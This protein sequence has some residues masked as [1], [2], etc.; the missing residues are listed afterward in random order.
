MVL[1][2]GRT[3]L[4]TKFLDEGTQ[5]YVYLCIVDG[6]RAC[7]KI[8]K[9]GSATTDEQKL[10]LA[11]YAAAGRPTKHFVKILDFVPSTESNVPAGYVMEW[12]DTQALKGISALLSCDTLPPYRVLVDLAL[13]FLISLKALHGRGLAYLDI[14]DANVL[15]DFAGGRHLK[16]LDPDNITPDGMRVGVSGTLGAIAPE[17]LRDSSPP[18]VQTDLYSASV[19][20]FRLLH[21]G[22][23]PLYGKSHLR[24]KVDNEK[25][26][27]L[28]EVHKPL[29]VYDEQDESNRPHESHHGRLIYCWFALTAAMKALFVRAFSEGLRSPQK[30][31]RE[32]EWIDALY[33]LRGLIESCPKCGEERFVEPDGSKAGSKSTLCRKCRSPFDVGPRF[34]V[35]DKDLVLTPGA[36]VLASQAGETIKR[37]GDRTVAVVGSV[38]KKREKVALRNV[39]TEPWEVVVDGKTKQVMPKQAVLVSPGMKLSLTATSGVGVVKLSS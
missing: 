34:V 4:V 14:S 9:L 25:V 27:L 23:H 17:I 7:L 38:G 32:T 2:S 1:A 36:S 37:Q 11:R 39:S 26:R 15:F 13:L 33:R 3:A 22:M 24:F 10:H 16:F 30:R 6:V 5:G 12:V 18:S 8:F 19:L 31:V 28:M 21:G 20:V 29:F 35:G